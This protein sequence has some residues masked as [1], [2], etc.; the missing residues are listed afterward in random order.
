MRLPTSMCTSCVTVGR[1]KSYSGPAKYIK[2]FQNQ[3]SGGTSKQH[4]LCHRNITATQ[5]I[6]GPWSFSSGNT[7]TILMSSHSR[8]RD[9]QCRQRTTEYLAD[10]K[11]LLSLGICFSK[12]I[13]YALVQQN[14]GYLK[15]HK[16]GHKICL[17][18]W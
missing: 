12:T 10:L 1:L 6:T 14:V 2:I 16:L 8:R 9:L 3:S 5:W 17:R 4:Q 13:R 11:L 7:Q 18:G 15:H